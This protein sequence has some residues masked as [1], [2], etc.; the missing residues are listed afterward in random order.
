ML[1]TERFNA[2]EVDKAAASSWVS[3]E[4]HHSGAQL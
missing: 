1:K 2:I 3:K 4:P